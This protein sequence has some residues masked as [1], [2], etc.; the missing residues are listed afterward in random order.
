MKR[1]RD[2]KRHTLSAGNRALIN[3]VDLKEPQIRTDIHDVIIDG[4]IEREIDQIIADGKDPVEVLSDKILKMDLD[5]IPPLEIR[6]TATRG[7]GTVP[8]PKEAD[9]TQDVEPAAPQ[10]LNLQTLSAEQKQE[11]L[12][13]FQTD[14]PINDILA[15][16]STNSY[17]LYQLVHRAGLPLRQGGGRPSSFARSEARAARREQQE[18]PQNTP[19]VSA[20]PVAAPPP[21]GVVSGL[22]E[23]TVTYLVKVTQTRVVAAKSFN[24]AA[25][26]VDDGE[27]D[28]EV[29]SVARVT[30]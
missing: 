22:T 7:G 14:T 21:N 27:G 20:S 23:W 4:L 18:M 10:K 12:D 15:A 9:R 6:P 8:P 17:V 3:E 26:A 13:L 30:K 19:P 1:R 24:D 29:L 16:Y 25:A 2:I 28:I 5:R 11:M